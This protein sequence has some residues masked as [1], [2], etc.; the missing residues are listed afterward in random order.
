MLFRSQNHS[1]DEWI[2]G[3]S[4]T[5][6]KILMDESIDVKN[7]YAVKAGGITKKVNAIEL[8]EWGYCFELNDNLGIQI[9]AYP[10][11]VELIYRQ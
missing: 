9:F 4:R 3:V 6:G 11:E 7:L 10:Q 1:D 8:T 5:E 2:C